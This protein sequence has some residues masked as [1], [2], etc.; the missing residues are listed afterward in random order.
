[1]LSN[2]LLTI[3]KIH[4]QTF[5]LPSVFILIKR[6]DFSSIISSY[7]C[8]EIDK[9][10]HSIYTWFLNINIFFEKY[11]IARY[12]YLWSSNIIF[13]VFLPSITKR[14]CHNGKRSRQ[15]NCTAKEHTSNE[16]ISRSWNCKQGIESTDIIRS[17]IYQ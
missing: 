11:W 7:L 12:F 17:K 3:D 2:Y 13:L 4:I 14:R 8:N 9:N 5:R 10:T 16:Y 15:L 6:K 1:M